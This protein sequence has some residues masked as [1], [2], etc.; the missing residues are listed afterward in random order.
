MLKKGKLKN[1]M[2]WNSGKMDHWVPE[3]G[4]SHKYWNKWDGIIEEA[5]IEEGQKQEEADILLPPI[6]AFS[7]F[8]RNSSSSLAEKLHFPKSNFLNWWWQEVRNDQYV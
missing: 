1:G 5:Q 7:V 3:S 6:F 4:G 8:P 2:L